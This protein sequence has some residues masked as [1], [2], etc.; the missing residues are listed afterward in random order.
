M[1]DEQKAAFWAEWEAVKDEV[2]A[3]VDTL[4][5]AAF[6]DLPLQYGID[7]D[8]WTFWVLKRREQREQGQTGE[9]A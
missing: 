9:A 7:L 2:A 4:L 1:T 3:E 8:R 5:M 6:D